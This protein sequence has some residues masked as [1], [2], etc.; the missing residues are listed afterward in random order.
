MK[1]I[2]YSTKA[3]PMPAGPY[4]QAIRRGNILALAGQ[5]GVDPNTGQLVAGGVSEQ[6]RQALTNLR[7]V[8]DEAGASLADIVMMRVYLTDSTHFGPMNEA[9]RNSF[10]EPF[11][12]RTTVF[13]GLPPGMLIELDAL[14]VV[15]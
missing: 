6:T 7:A 5:V 1:S 12:S 3:A 4:S 8:L 9:Y 11:P 13:V 14:A 2:A 10:E 15:D